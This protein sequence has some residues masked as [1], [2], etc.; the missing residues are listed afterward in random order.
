MR[1]KIL[2]VLA[3]GFEEIEAVTPIDVLRRAGAEVTVAGVG[4][5]EVSGSRGL[6]VV[7]DVRLE[8]YRDLPDLVVL[9]GGS[10]G[11]ENLSRSEALKTLLTKMKDSGRWIGAICAAPAVVLAGQGQ[12]SGKKA[13][14]YPGYEKSFPSDARFVEDRVVRDGQLVTSRGPGTALE[15]S[16][17]LAKQVVDPALAAKIS[18]LMLAKK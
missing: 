11:A 5:L 2:V 12:L 10:P 6:K 3:T 7:A 4:S 9:P 13:T 17:E 15:F 1:K 18:E 14:C 8:D 16:L